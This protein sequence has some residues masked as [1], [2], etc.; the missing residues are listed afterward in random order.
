VP[1]DDVCDCKDIKATMGAIEHTIDITPDEDLD[2]FG[3]DDDI[4]AASRR[5]NADLSPS[6]PNHCAPMEQSLTGKE[7]SKYPDQLLSALQAVP[8]ALTDLTEQDRAIL[9]RAIS[10]V[11][12]NEDTISDQEKDHIN[13]LLARAHR[14]R[15]TAQGGQQ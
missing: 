9:A 4:W 11:E 10:C 2:G 3:P 12:A 1:A 14:A 6:D 7:S 8:D 5:E 15:S 13:W